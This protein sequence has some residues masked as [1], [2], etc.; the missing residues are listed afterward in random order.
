MKPPKH[1]PQPGAP[2]FDISPKRVAK[3]IARHRVEDGKGFRL[4]D[5]DPGDTGGQKMHRDEAEALLAA[6]V[7]ALSDFQEKL[8]AQDQWAL[9]CVLQAMDAAGKDGT[10]KHVMSGV[11]PQGVTVTSFKAPG[12]EALDHD[13][14]WRANRAL[15]ERGRIGIFNRSYYE[16]VLVVRVH[17]EI[18]HRQDLPKEL[19]TKHI[20]KERLESIAAYEEFLGR[21]GIVV[22]K[23]FLHLSKDEQKRRFLGRLDEKEK[24]WKF[25]ISDIKERAFWDDYQEAF[26]EAIRATAAPHAPWYVVPADNK[27]YSRLVVVAAMNHA[28]RG[29]DLDF[30]ELDDAQRAALDAARKQLE[31][32]D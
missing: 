18:L 4:K 31:A 25:S 24:N 32:E 19:I 29:L 14:L 15:P 13:F 3:L 12:P 20:W 6:G 17:P 22:L 8:Y 28:L 16:E 7:A 2:P 5:H 21:Q 11:N 30:P 9:L 23:F 1:A 10:I 26:E 27:W